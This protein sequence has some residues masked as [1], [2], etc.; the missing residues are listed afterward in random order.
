MDESLLP[1]ICLFLS[2]ID[3]FDALPDAVRAELAA[4][5]DISYWVQG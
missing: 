1:N 4:Q 2:Q 5:I 3:P